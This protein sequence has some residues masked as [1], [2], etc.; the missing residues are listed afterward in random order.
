MQTLK[1][2]LP[3]NFARRVLMVEPTHFFLNEETF[4]DNKFMNKVQLDQLQSSNQAKE[5]FWR[6]RDNIER[7]E[8]EVLTYK[9]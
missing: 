8:V 3:S 6:F 9:Q 1:R 2:G 4:K 5:E 7:H